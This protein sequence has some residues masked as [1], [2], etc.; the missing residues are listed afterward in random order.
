MIPVR[1]DRV[2]GGVTSADDVFGRRR[3]NK[4]RRAANPW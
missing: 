4:V 3:V 2:F 1:R